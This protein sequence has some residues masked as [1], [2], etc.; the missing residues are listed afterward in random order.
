MDGCI[1]VTLSP[2]SFSYL[3]DSKCPSVSIFFVENKKIKHTDNY[4]KTQDLF[5][6]TFI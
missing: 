1:N 2:V 5:I 6:Y 3:F 4:A